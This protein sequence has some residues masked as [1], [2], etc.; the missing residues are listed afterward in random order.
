MQTNEKPANSSDQT[1][2]Q[3][4]E[5]GSELTKSKNGNIYTLTVIGQIEGHQTLPENAKTTK[6]EHVLP[7]L[8]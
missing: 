1:H 2:E 6:Y 7:L 8:S 3:I 4:I 5:L